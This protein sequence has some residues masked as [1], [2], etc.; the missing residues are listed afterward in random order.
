M[1]VWARGG[2]GD[3]C[4][5]GL[6]HNHGLTRNT[7]KFIRRN[8]NYTSQIIEIMSVYAFYSLGHGVDLNPSNTRVR[9]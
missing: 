3:F 5:A 6:D 2:G 8:F 7:V 9:E 1:Q 4:K